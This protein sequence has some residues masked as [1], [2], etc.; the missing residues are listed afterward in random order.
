LGS[1]YVLLRGKRE[2]L[3]REGGTKFLRENEREI[4]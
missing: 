4:P 2:E 1:L 3:L